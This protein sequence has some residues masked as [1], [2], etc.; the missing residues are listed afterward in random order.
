MSGEV[1]KCPILHVRPKFDVFTLIRLQERQKDFKRM[2]L[3]RN[4]RTSRENEMTRHHE[5][6]MKLKE[7]DWTSGEMK[8]KKND[9]T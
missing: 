4:Y 2:T 8:L 5:K 6:K 7:N 3:K 1:E 9:R